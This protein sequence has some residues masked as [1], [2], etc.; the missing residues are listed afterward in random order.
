MM[1][2][3]RVLS[4]NNFKCDEDNK[5]NEGVRLTSGEEYS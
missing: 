1:K 2:H 3:Y 5:K 4:F